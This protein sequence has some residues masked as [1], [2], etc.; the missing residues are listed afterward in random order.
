MR[1]SYPE[2]QRSGQA[3]RNPVYYAASGGG[4]EVEGSAVL[5]LTQPAELRQARY[6]KTVLYEERARVQDELASHCSRLVKLKGR[7]AKASIRLLTQQIA[8][9]RRE[10]YEL[11]C[12][13]E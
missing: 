4:G 12:L 1:A 2:R 13:I 11:D 8:D 3:R 6:F 5:P 7:N 10:E 9:K